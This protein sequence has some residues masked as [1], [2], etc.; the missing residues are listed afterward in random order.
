MSRFM[1]D[2]AHL[3][4]GIQRHYTPGIEVG[5]WCTLAY[6]LGTE[7][8]SGFLGPTANP[9]TNTTLGDGVNHPW[10]HAVCRATT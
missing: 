3:L 2:L 4:V 5:Q 7:D 9:S 8:D 1:Y 6:N 10:N